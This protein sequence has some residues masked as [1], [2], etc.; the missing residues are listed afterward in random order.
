[1]SKL[2]CL[3]NYRLSDLIDA[4][5]SLMKL[6]PYASPFGAVIT[7]GKLMG[8]ELVE[9]NIVKNTYIEVQYSLVLN[10][11]GVE[12]GC[13]A[14]NASDQGAGLPGSAALRS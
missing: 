10:C 2:H 7:E 4:A 8:G 14:A 5:N 12:C 11:C 6:H 13:V 1:M 9:P 3:S